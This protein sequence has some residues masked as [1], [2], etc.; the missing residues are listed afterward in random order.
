MKLS[1]HLILAVLVHHLDLLYGFVFP[2]GGLLSS[3]IRTVS[4]TLGSHSF[5][6]IDEYPDDDFSH[7]R[8]YNLTSKDYTPSKLQEISASVIKEVIRS[9]TPIDT[10]SIIDVILLY[11]LLNMWLI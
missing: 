11:Q 3:R 6:H 1:F 8:G 4:N 9:K 2:F 10:V 7:I 5:I